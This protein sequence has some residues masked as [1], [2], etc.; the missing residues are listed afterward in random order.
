ML[1]ARL[2][3]DPSRAVTLL[4]AGPD[5]TSID[6]MPRDVADASRPTTGHDWGYLSE[7]DG[8]GRAIELPRARILGGC[9]STNATF[10]VR[11]APGDYDGWGRDWSFDEVL[12]FFR[13]LET[14]HDFENAWHGNTGPIDITRARELTEHSSAFLDAAVALGYEQIPDHNH[15]GAHG[16]GLAPR[17]AFNGIRV[18]TALGYLLPARDRPNLT[19]RPNSSVDCVNLSGSRATGVRLVDGTSVDADEV[20]LS[21]GAYGS[22]A[23]LLRS[24]VGQDL[25]V[26]ENLIDHPFLSVDYP[27]RPAPVGD[28]FQ[29]LVN[30]AYELHLIAGSPAE[31]VFII[32]VG[33][34]RPQSRGTVRLDQDN[35]PRITLGGIAHPDDRARMV[36]GIERAR[37][38]ARTPPLDKLI[39][40]KELGPDEVDVS[41][42]VRVYHHACGTCAMGTVVDSQARVLGVDGLRVVDASIMPTI[43]AANT[44]LPVMML[45]ERIAAMMSA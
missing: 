28:W 39:T 35:Q 13:K 41:D 19:V 25:P 42:A 7:P 2:S 12:P 17:N 3:E 36:E 22:P 15:P 31:D 44:N 5:I 9:S 21:A 38:L 34:L 32:A 8:R 10:A 26:G 6:A 40:G 27:T 14:D 1:A 4:E 23:I 30:D 43:P 16:V 37:E 33:L 45:A 24:G 11:G 18:S 29:V 20:I